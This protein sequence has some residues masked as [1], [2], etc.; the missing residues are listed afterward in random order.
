MN[1]KTLLEEVVQGN[2]GP[3]DVAKVADELADAVRESF[4]DKFFE[5]KDRKHVSASNAGNC[6]RKLAYQYHGFPKEPL[7]LRSR[8]SM[9]LGDVFEAATVALFKVHPANDQTGF[10]REIEFGGM[11]G[12]IDWEDAEYVTDAKCLS[13]TGFDKETGK[14]GISDAFGYATQGAI[15]SA[16][17]G[18]KFRH[19]AINKNNGDVAVVEHDP[20]DDDLL[21]RNAFRRKKDV[22]AS[23]P[24]N[25]PQRE[26]A[27]LFDR[28]QNKSYLDIQCVY[29]PFK[30]ECWNITSEQP[31]TPAYTRYY[32]TA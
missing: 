12:H 10:Q 29:C 3:G 6:V 30:R 11:K 9:F 14:E 31:I 2:Y 7:T 24:E 19:L 25:L 18:K 1:P 17:T 32:A 13:K 4:K 23:T 28:K 21:V 8:F 22:E 26:Y 16:A 27:L 15:Y 20:K 5:G